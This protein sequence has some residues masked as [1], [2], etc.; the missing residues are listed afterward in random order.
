MSPTT[1][2]VGLLSLVMLLAGTAA[3]HAQILIKASDDVNFKLGVLGQFQADTLEDPLNDTNSN[4]LFIRRLRL[5]FAG[6]VAKNVT[7][8]IET[9][10]PNLGKAVPP[11]GKT[12]APEFIQD[13]YGEFKVSDAFAL[14]AGLM[15][16]PF[17][18]NSLQ[19]A[20]TLLPIDYGA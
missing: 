8:F 15:F 2:R 17:S 4:N 13:A 11:A 9:D 18:R 20:A 3:V 7:F 14:D 19:S 16:V 1:S 10:S 6:Q 12:V 5:M